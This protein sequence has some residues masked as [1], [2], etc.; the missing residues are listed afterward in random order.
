MRRR[1]KVD[2]V[3][4]YPDQW[5][6]DLIREVKPMLSKVATSSFV[7]Y[8]EIGLKILA[9]GYKKGAWHSR[10][11]LKFTKELGISGATFSLF[12][13]LAEMSQEEF[14]AAA[15]T[16]GSINEWY[17]Q[18]KPKTMSEKRASLIRG[19]VSQF[20][21][22][23]KAIQEILRIEKAYL[24]EKDLEEFARKVQ[25]SKETPLMAF[26][27][28][29]YLPKASKFKLPNWVLVGFSA[30]IEKEGLA[31]DAEALIL[32][33]LKKRLSKSFTAQEIEEAAQAFL[34]REWGI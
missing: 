9:S 14:E 11:K 24:G 26:I 27:K 34:A 8:R 1:A 5:L 28:Y 20:P 12:V 32:A 3:L 23:A 15:R 19:L 29:Y 16:Y 13:R 30:L 2:Y 18:R 10:H 17:R 31:S 4:E 25:Y 22:Q 7:A 21:G 6:D 33:C